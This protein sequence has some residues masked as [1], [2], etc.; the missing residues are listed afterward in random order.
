MEPDARREKIPGAAEAA[1]AASVPYSGTITILFSDIRGF[2]EYT[3]QHGD[4]A[5]YGVLREHDATVRKQIEA[6][7]GTVVKTQ[8]DSFIPGPPRQ[9]A[10]RMEGVEYVDRGLRALKGFQEP[11]RLSEVRWARAGEAPDAQGTET[12]ADARIVR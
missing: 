11:Q 6:F 3:E 1:P 12:R 4:E 2:T 9:G 5:A 7:G 8:G 10:G